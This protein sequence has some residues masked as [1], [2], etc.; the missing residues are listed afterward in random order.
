MLCGERYWTWKEDDISWSIHL[1]RPF[2]NENLLLLNL[3]PFPQQQPSLSQILDDFL[4]ILLPIPCI[5][6]CLYS[7]TYG[8]CIKNSWTNGH[9]NDFACQSYFSVRLRTRVKSLWYIWHKLHYFMSLIPTI[10]LCMGCK[11]IM[12]VLC[13]VFCDDE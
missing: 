4:F 12:I 3:I 7:L 5:F 2:L 11:S 9:L 13:T 1:S 8:K 10:E 6:I